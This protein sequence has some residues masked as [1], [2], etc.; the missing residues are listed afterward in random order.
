[1]PT[2]NK[3]TVPNKFLKPGKVQTIKGSILTP[4]YGGLRFVLNIANMAG[5]VDDPIYKVFNKK[6]PKI[7]IDTRSWWATKTGLGTGAYKMGSIR[8]LAVQSDIWAI[9]MLARDENL[10][11][12]LAGLQ[13]CLKEVCKMAKY[14]KATVACSTIL[15]DEIPELVDLLKQELVNQGVSVSFYEE[16]SV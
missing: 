9:T 10:E 12:D 15:T 13:K 2:D 5:K 3:T 11:L 1:M 14:E 16:P 8:D 7:K 6:W 4:H